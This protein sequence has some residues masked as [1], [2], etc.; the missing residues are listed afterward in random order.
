LPTINVPG[1]QTSVALEGLAKG[2]S[3]RIQI[4]ATNQ[5]GESRAATTRQLFYTNPGSPTN[6][7]VGGTQQNTVTWTLPNDNGGVP[8]LR[9]TLS[10]STNQGITWNNFTL[11]PTAT[12]YTVKQV[13]NLPF[14]V[15]VSATN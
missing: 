8:I 14:S 12:I 5:F 11:G 2:Q 15:K 4:Q 1:S 6:I 10:Y 7:M 9:Q 3:Y 13:P